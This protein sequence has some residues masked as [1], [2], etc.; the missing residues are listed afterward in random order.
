ME[1]V[2]GSIKSAQ[3]QEKRRFVA[4]KFQVSVYLVVKTEFIAVTVARQAWADECIC[5][6]L[7]QVEVLCVMFCCRLKYFVLCYVMLQIEVLCVMLCCRLKYCVIWSVADRSIVCYV[8][9]QI[10]VL[11]YVLLQ[12]EVLCVMFCCRLKYCVLCCRLK[13]CVLV[14]CRLNYC[15]IFGCRLKYC[16]LRS[17][18]D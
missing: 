12:I 6:V 1:V 18:A 15:V 10:K 14:C 16:V 3:N 11:C 8:P 5:S 7:F 2:A 17:V 13:Y 9:L 4:D